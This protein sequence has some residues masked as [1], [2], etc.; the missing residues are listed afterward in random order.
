MLIDFKH[1]FPRY[2]IC[3]SGILHLGANTGQEA[4]TY[5]ELGVSPVIW[6]EALPDI[7]IQLQEHLAAYPGQRALLACVSDRDD[8]R[9]TFNIA[10]NGAQ[11]SSFLKFGTHRLEHP[12]VC[13][14]GKVTMFTQRVDTLLKRHDI[15]LQGNDWLLNADLQGVELLALRGMG[16]LIHNFRYAYIEVN[17]RPLYQGCA[18]VGEIDQY[19]A[20]FGFKGVEKKMTGA[21]WGDKLYIRQT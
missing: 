20:Q 7:H 2:Q 1:L 16:E 4:Q 18:L 5:H 21:G 15:Q 14:V 12:S 11:S 9:V 13:Y 8:E 19:L 3:P 17:E 6:V 10:S